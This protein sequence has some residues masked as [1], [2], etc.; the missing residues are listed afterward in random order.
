MPVAGDAELAEAA[1]E[2]LARLALVAH[3]ERKALAAEIARLK[4]A[5][6]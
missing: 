4:A 2:A 6:E 3:D 1:V 5:A